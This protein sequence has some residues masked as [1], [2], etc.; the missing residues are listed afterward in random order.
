MTSKEAFNIIKFNPD[1]VDGLE[2]LEAFK[3]VEKDLEELENY[4]KIMT[5]PILKLISDQIKFE[6]IQKLAVKY[7]NSLNYPDEKFMNKVLKV[8][9]E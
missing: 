7:L 2:Y 1:N 9:E 8:L 6:E 5:K 3:V 4:R